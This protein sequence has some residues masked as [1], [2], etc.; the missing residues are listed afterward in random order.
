MNAD[1]SFA[2]MREAAARPLPAPHP[3]V[4]AAKQARSRAKQR[5]LLQAGRRL[6]AAHELAALSV[7]QIA[8]EAGVAVGTFYARF[9]DKDAWFAELLQEVGDEVVA[10][11]QALLGG[12]RW[13]R[14][15]AA[16]RVDLIVRHLVDVHRRHRGLMRAALGD[17]AQA[18]RFGLPL[19]GYGRRIADAVHAALAAH[20]PGVPAVRRRERI[21]IAL[22]LVYGVLVNAV[23]RDPGPLK[24]D[25]PRLPRELADAFRAAARVEG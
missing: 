20:L 24:L 18:S 4:H 14:A 8:A 2:G 11:M 22:Q 17:A 25:D 21:G 15:A 3:G 7:A 1:S 5:A 9:I 16:R 23:L 6:L 13:A 19:H 10:E 12:E